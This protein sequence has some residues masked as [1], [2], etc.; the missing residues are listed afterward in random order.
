MPSSEAPEISVVVPVRNGERHI[1]ALL[2]ALDHQTLLTKA[3]EV[4][5]VDDGSTDGTSELVADW[6]ERDPDRRILIR[7]SHAGRSTARNVG[8]EHARG[9]WIAFTD[10][11]TIPDPMWL[12]AAREATESLRTMA[13]EGAI[14]PV[15]QEFEAPPQTHHYVLN[16]NGGYYMTANMIYSRDLLN[17][18]GGFDAQ[19]EAIEDWDLAARVME[20]GYEIPFAPNVLVRHP[21]Y[22]RT[23]L[24]AL[25]ETRRVRWS[26]LAVARHRD[27]FRAHRQQ[28]RP[29]THVE[30][31]ALLG[32][33]ALIMASRS[34][35]GSRIALAIMASNGIR[36]ALGSGKVIGGPRRQIPLRLAL[37]LAYPATKAF[38][39][40][41]GCARFRTFYW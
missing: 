19:F 14:E 31:D 28:L 41:E 26:A 36:R 16:G 30:I 18:V 21:V 15:F 1:A 34:R 2:Q 29:L 22:R 5:V 11:D 3:F 40:L 35:G 23:A 17:R 33:F 13:I 38:W 6:V 4:L 7:S 37:S 10:S 20:L 25:R 12:E 8:I 9:Q 24:G 27:L 39:W 32:F